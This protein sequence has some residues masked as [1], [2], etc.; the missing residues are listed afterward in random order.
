MTRILIGSAALALVA[1]ACSRTPE[2]PV[3]C[4]MEARPGIAVAVTDSA[5]GQPVTGAVTL[6]LREGTHVERVEGT[7]PGGEIFAAY[8][9]AGTY[10][11]TVAAP[12]Y[13]IWRRTGVRVTADEC[14]V[15][16]T[17]LAAR[18]LKE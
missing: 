11:V 10:E 15:R 14:H 2:P 3:A 6:V 7:T 5:T 13:R 17:R 12:G 8:E 18:L 16:A 9:R 1:A 4:T